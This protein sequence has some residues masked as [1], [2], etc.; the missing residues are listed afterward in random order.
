MHP[1]RRRWLDTKTKAA[2]NKDPR[3]HHLKRRLLALGGEAGIFMPRTPWLGRLLQRGTIFAGESRLRKGLH[4]RCHYNSARLW[5]AARAQ[6]KIVTGYALSDD[7]CWWQHSWVLEPSEG[8]P[9]IIE[10]TNKRLLYF[11]VVLTPQE[12]KQF[13]HAETGQS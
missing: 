10:T 11:G 1:G 7:G 8:Q 4:G 2:I 6:R 9:P 13:L 5:S 3:L 12:S